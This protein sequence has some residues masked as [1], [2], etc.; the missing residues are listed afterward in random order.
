MK[1]ECQFINYKK[2]TI[3]ET[4]FSSKSDEPEHSLPIGKI[5]WEVKQQKVVW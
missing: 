2:K 5:T 4:R 1:S 3:M